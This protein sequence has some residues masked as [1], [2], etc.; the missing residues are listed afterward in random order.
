MKKK[1]FIIAG[2]KSG[3]L[4]GSKILAKIDKKK[5]AIEG[6]GGSL[7]EAA[8]LKSR[9]PM[10]ELS[11][12]GF[13]EILPRAFKLLQ[14]INDTAKYIVET[15]Q[16]IVLTIDSPGFCFR[17]ME[18]VKK[19][20]KENQIKKVHFVAPSVWAYRKGRAR[21]IS[22][23]YDRLFCILPFEPPYFEKY[24]LKTIFVGHPIFDKDS[25]EYSF[26]SGLVS[27]K[28]DS[29][30]ISVT[31]G[32][33]VNEVKK[34]LPIILKSIAMLNKKYGDFTYNFLATEDTYDIV[35]KAIRASSIKNTKIFTKQNDKNKSLEDSVLAIAKS[36]TNTLEIAASST[37]MVVIYKFNG[38]TNFIVRILRYFSNIKFANLINIISAKEVIPEL[39]LN[40]CN[41]A[42]IFNSVSN[43]LENKQLRLEQISTGVK[44]LEKLGFNGN[45]SSSARIV[46]EIY[47][48]TDA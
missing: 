27:Y 23:I 9:F 48:L 43:M 5:F 17:V 46:E 2:E 22:K 16:D 24:G 8:G 4:L 12:M 19:L 30:I 33:R 36:G 44:V 3:D 11:V 28:E 1:L 40:R 20:D 31:A 18:K 7:M 25:L 45:N 21:K 39:I 35:A 15:R 47:R 14:L 6:I 13:F 37:P 42:N 38:I 29:K 34:L 32:S 10:K 26:N 41:S